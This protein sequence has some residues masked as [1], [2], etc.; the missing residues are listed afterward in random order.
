MTK[1]IEAL[2][3]RSPD[4]EEAAHALFNR[5]ILRHRC[6]RTLVTDRGTNFTSVLFSKLCKLL[7]IQKV[8]TTAHHPEGN[9]VVQR[10]NGTIVKSLA[11][12]VNEDR[13]NWSELPPII[14]F[15]YPTSFHQSIRIT[16][17]EA[18]FGRR[19]LMPLD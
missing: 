19:A 7:Q 13:D 18:M 8:Y 14:L 5:V 4:A 1:W 17:F 16:R 10:A 11:L 3:L 2:P 9:G 15:S 12:L 6:C